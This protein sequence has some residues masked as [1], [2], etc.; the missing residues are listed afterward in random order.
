MRYTSRVVRMHDA[1]NVI[2]IR[3]EDRPYRTRELTA[4]RGFVVASAA[5]VL[6][7]GACVTAVLLIWGSD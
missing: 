6:F 7:W 3:P 2:P 5:S 4:F 1:S